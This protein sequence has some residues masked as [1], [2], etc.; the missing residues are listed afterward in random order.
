MLNLSN[1]IR[2]SVLRLCEKSNLAQELASCMYRTRLEVQLYKHK[3]SNFLKPSRVFTQSLLLIG[4][5]Q[6]GY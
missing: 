3:T 4:C 1:I 5:E 6:E 2:A